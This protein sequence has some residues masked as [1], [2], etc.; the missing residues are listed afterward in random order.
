VPVP[1]PAPA[2]PKTT[3]GTKSG[4]STAKTAEINHPATKMR[5]C[6]SKAANAVEP[7]DTAPTIDH[8]IEPTDTPA[9]APTSMSGDGISTTQDSSSSSITKSQ[10]WGPRKIITK[11]TDDARLTGQ[12]IVLILLHLF[13]L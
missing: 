4:G 5:G 13:C 1:A 6:S 11:P 8:S 9:G 7:V 2:L 10:T 3:G 12:Y